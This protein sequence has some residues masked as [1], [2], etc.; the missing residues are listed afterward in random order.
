MKYLPLIFLLLSC[1]KPAPTELGVNDQK[2]SACES[3][4]NCIVSFDYQDGSYLNPIESEEE[5]ERIRMKIAGIVTKDSNAKVITDQ[6][7]YLYVQYSASL[8]LTDDVEFWFGEAG[9]VH[10]KSRGRLGFTDLGSNKDRIEKIRF[11]FHQ[12]DF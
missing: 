9:K 10:F 2:F 7:D 1:Q 4:S 8:G 3:T 5:P 6:A 11:K 12:N